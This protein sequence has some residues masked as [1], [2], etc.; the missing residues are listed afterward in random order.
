VNTWWRPRERQQLALLGDAGADR[1]VVPVAGFVTLQM[2]DMTTDTLR[3]KTCNAPNAVAANDPAF[4]ATDRPFHL[5]V[6]K[7]RS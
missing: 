3:I 7:L 1:H 4:V 6:R 5:H 2:E